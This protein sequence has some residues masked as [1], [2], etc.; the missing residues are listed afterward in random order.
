MKMIFGGI[1]L[2]DINQLYKKR[3]GV[4][5]LDGISYRVEGRG[6]HGI[7]GASAESMTALLDVMCGVTVACDG[8][9]TVFGEDV[10]LAPKKVKRRLGYMRRPLTFYEDMTVYE[11]LVFVGEAKGV[12]YDKLFKN[13]KSALELTILDEVGDRLISRLTASQRQRL[14]LC[15]A[16]LGNPDLIVLNEP[17][18]NMD[19]KDAESLLSLIKKLG[20]VKTV[21]VA[22]SIPSVVEE[23][24]DDLLVISNGKALTSGS[25]EEIVSRLAK[26]KALLLTVK[27]REQSVVEKLSEIGS[28]T[29]CTVLSR[30]GDSITFKVEHRKDADPR[31]EIFS[32]F[33]SSGMPVLSMEDD[34]LKLSDLYI[35]LCDNEVKNEGGEGR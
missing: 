35:K 12:P 7:L 30:G 5:L 19:Q 6:V 13:I 18:A 22:T 23:I 24:C 26:N 34:S 20:G 28:V 33:T 4:T 17:T 15:E 16:M 31:E 8:D 29:D 32:L 2:I 11:H 21:I 1:V 10:S 25:V 9:V 14:G 3:G 27:G